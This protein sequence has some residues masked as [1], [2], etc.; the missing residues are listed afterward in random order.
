MKED[1]PYCDVC[2]KEYKNK[3][4]LISHMTTVQDNDEINCLNHLHF[5][6][7]EVYFYSLIAIPRNK[8]IT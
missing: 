5:Y 6:L 2:K 4:D 1:S 7:Q 3:E 8:L